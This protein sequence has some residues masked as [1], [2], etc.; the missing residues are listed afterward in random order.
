[1]DDF[2]VVVNY[3]DI[4]AKNYSLSAGQYFDVKI[5]YTDIT[6]QEFDQKLL[7]FQNRLN[8]MFAESRKL[9]KEIEKQLEGLVYEI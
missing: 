1:M 9:E 2:T 4:V 6:P 8:S 5:E 3:D 7:G